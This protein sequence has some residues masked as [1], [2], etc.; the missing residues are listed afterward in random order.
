MS[1]SIHIAMA[2]ASALLAAYVAISLSGFFAVARWRQHR[3]FFFIAVTGSLY[4]LGDLSAGLVLPVRGH[5]ALGALQVLAAGAHIALWIG[6]SCVDLGPLG[7]GCQRKAQGLAIG[8]AALSAVP[9]LGTTGRIR[10]AWIPLLSGN[11]RS[12][13]L[14][15]FGAAM[16]GLMAVLLSI[17]VVRYGRA[18]AKGSRQDRLHFAGLLLLVCGGVNDVLEIVG[19]TRAPH[20][21]DAC[22]ALCICALGIALTQRWSSDIRSLDELSSGLEEKV[23]ARTQELERTWHAFS[24][25]DRLAAVGRLAGGMAHEINNPGSALIS[26]VEYLLNAGTRE[27]RLPADAVDTL[28][29]SLS[30]AKRISNTVRQLLL[31]TRAAAGDRGDQTFN[32]AFVAD[33][34]A[35]AVERML[36]NRVRIKS[37]VPRNIASPG[38]GLLLEQALVQLITNGVLAIPQDREDG[39][40]RLTGEFADGVLVLQVCDNGV[41]MDEAVAQRLF[42]PFFTTRRAGDGA[43]LGLAVSLGL[44][45]ALGGEV[46][47]QSTPGQGTI[48]TLVLE[49][50]LEPEPAPEP[51]D[52][53]PR[54]ARPPPSA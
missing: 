19:A 31:L 8:A 38:R 21:S 12:N 53:A 51:L 22:L 44:V 39:E 26:N 5:L 25:A 42:E 6:Y 24:R 50:Q 20:L 32:V 46:R 4:C 41:G 11:L 23:T 18:F 3:L 15:P 33:L 34:A 29:E 35:K 40:V 47:V 14:T 16:L 54:P 1:F 37:L 48:M 27:G 17:P 43:G 2:G 49:G 9:F 7:G 30:A 45:Q 36:G 52:E 28:E 13:E 10:E